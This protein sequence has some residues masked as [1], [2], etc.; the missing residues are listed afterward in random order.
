MAMSRALASR[1]LTALRKQSNQ[2]IPSIQFLNHRSFSDKASNQTDKDKETNESKDEQSND[3]KTDETNEQSTDPDTENAEPEKVYKRVHV[4]IGLFITGVVLGTVTHIGVKTKY[5]S[6][7]A[8]W[9][10]FACRKLAEE[11][12]NA[13]LDS[14]LSLDA[15]NLSAPIRMSVLSNEKVIARLIEALSFDNVIEVQVKAATFWFAAA[16]DP[17][18]LPMLEPYARELATALY[19]AAMSPLSSKDLSSLSLGALRGL[20]SLQSAQTVLLN[21]EQIYGIS[22]AIRSRVPEVTGTASD[23]MCALVPAM[24]EK[25]IKSFRFNADE[26]RSLLN[27][28][29]NLGTM[30]SEQGMPIQSITCFELALDLDPTNV[31][32]ANALGLEKLKVGNVKDAALLLKRSLKVDPSNLD[33]AFNLHRSIITDLKSK[34]Q[35]VPDEVWLDAVNALKPALKAVVNTYGSTVA[36]SAQSQSLIDAVPMLSQSYHLLCKAYEHLGRLD[37]AAE[38]AHEWSL[39]CAQDAVA[40]FTAG[41]LELLCGHIK[42]ALDQLNIAARKDPSKP[43]TQ[44]HRA[45]ALCDLGQYAAAHEACEQA[46]NI[47]ESR[48][49]ANA[50]DLAA[51][52]HRVEAD[53]YEHEGQLEAAAQSRL[54]VTQFRPHSAE[55][56]VRAADAAAKANQQITSYQQITEAISLWRQQSEKFQTRESFFAAHP[57]CSPIIDSVAHVCASVTTN[58]AV[59]DALCKELQQWNAR[60]EKK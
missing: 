6:W 21:R 10:K 55:E 20:A 46:K 5:G 53:I 45:R 15:A 38:C 14:S 44:I 40:H 4:I 22:R 26:S 52:V 51:T 9:M 39:N 30:Y 37:E 19:A 2:T 47:L 56:R 3:Q 54:K 60:W 58:D 8:M 33:A 1:C 57:R 59:V 12:A 18:T 7:S 49:V 24:K 17:L 50:D 48:Y 28:L 23:L 43:Q 31:I 27:A 41:R 13:L 11:G 16:Q 36:P 25:G 32:V 34:G 29:A 42:S 35:Q